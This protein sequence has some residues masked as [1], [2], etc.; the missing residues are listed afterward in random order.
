MLV[1][2]TAIYQPL[3]SNCEKLYQYKERPTLGVR[4]LHRCAELIS[5][6]MPL[7]R[8]IA[9]LGAKVSLREI[10]LS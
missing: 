9:K 1:D 4:N 8:L 2:E 10:Y 6:A 5:L 3:I 7:S